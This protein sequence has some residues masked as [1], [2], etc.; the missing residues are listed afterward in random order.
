MGVFY[1]GPLVPRQLPIWAVGI[2]FADTPA[3]YHMAQ[4]DLAVQDALDGLQRPRLGA[5]VPFVLNDAF[6]IAVASGARDTGGI[7]PAG[8]CGISLT[9]QFAPENFP[10]HLRGFRVGNDAVA[11]QGI[12][13]IAVGG[14]GAD[15]LTP[16]LLFPQHGAGFQRNIFGINIVDDIF[17]RHRQSVKGG[18]VGAVIS[19]A[20]GDEPN[21]QMG[22]DVLE[23]ML[24]LYMVSPKAREVFHHNAVD[25][26]TSHILD[27]PLKALALKVC[28]RLPVILILADEPKFLVLRNVLPQK[29]FLVLQSLV[30][31]IV[32]CL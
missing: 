12:F 30:V 23:K 14:V 5:C 13:D 22:E 2:K 15:E 11:V 3:L 28:A 29:C 18:L 1:H 16:G 27:Q 4:I 6:L 7:E 10:H 25:L 31:L 8:N 20:D 32:P 17:Q 24:Y 19:V 21:T 26:T 9:F